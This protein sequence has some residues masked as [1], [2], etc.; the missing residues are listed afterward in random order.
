MKRLYFTLLLI[1]AFAYCHATNLTIDDMQRVYSVKEWNSINQILA[2]KKWSYNN[3]E[4]DEYSVCHEYSYTWEYDKNNYS[5]PANGWFTV[6]ISNYGKGEVTLI[7]YQTFDIDGYA[8]ALSSID[9]NG[10]KLNKT[11][12]DN[13]NDNERII[14]TYS[15]DKFILEAII[16]KESFT[17]DEEEWVSGYWVGG[18]TTEY[19]YYTGQYKRV[20][21]DQKDYVSGHSKTIQKKDYVTRYIFNLKKVGGIYYKF[22]GHKYTVYQ[23]GNKEHE[24]TLKDGI[25]VGTYKTYYRMGKLARIIK[26]LKDSWIIEEY[27]QNGELFSKFTVPVHDEQLKYPCNYTFVGKGFYTCPLDRFG[28]LFEDNTEKISFKVEGSF[29]V[30]IFCNMISRGD[31]CPQ[32]LMVVDKDESPQTNYT[33]TEYKYGDKDKLISKTITNHNANNENYTT[34]DAKGRIIEKGQTQDGK[35]QGELIEREYSDSGVLLEENKAVYKDN[36]FNGL[37]VR[38]KYSDKGKL[39]KEQQTDYSDGELDGKDII[40]EYLPNGIKTI[41]SNSYKMGKLNGYCYKESYINGKRQLDYYET[42]VN[43]KMEGEVMGSD[44]D[45]V[46][47]AWYKN[48]VLQRLGIFRDGMMRFRS[49]Q[50]VSTDTTN[51]T[52]ITELTFKNDKPSGLGKFYYPCYYSDTIKMIKGKHAGELK[53]TKDF[54]NGVETVYSRFGT[55]YDDSTYEKIF[56]EVHSNPTTKKKEGL[57]TF[58]DSIGNYIYVTNYK[59][60]LL[61]GLSRYYQVSFCDGEYWAYFDKG[62]WTKSRFHDKEGKLIEIQKLS[63]SQVAVLSYTKDEKLARK[64]FYLVN[65]K[66]ISGFNNSDWVNIFAANDTYKT[67]EYYIYDDQERV[68]T[69]RKKDSNFIVHNDYDVKVTY[70]VHHAN[71]VPERFYELNTQDVMSGTIVLNNGETSEII[72]VKKGYRDGVTKII[73]NQTGKTIKKVKYSKG[74]VK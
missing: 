3:R 17:Y 26:I 36:K 5:R 33:Y 39:V 30:K 20:W 64:D 2:K 28:Y 66:T 62:I 8:D 56:F 68:I 53:Y 60:D 47:Y 51:L 65:T 37:L 72:K 70:W 10:Y 54:D 57:S 14:S 22:N 9:K 25:I 1:T 13:S 44:N 74:V 50:Y 52:L 6:T 55:M 38:K 32:L 4:E 29:K 71:A 43:G 63:L 21:T 58:K 31:N 35:Q 40:T 45:S 48:G 7:N 23:N 15:N 27:K 18:Y 41:E 69:Y 42:Y 61:D 49:P 24:C 34:Y 16:S 59:D 12:N 11:E 73:N 19:D 46:A 67:G